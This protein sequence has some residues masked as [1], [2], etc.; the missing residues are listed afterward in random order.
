MTLLL[1]LSALFSGSEVALF[2]LDKEKILTLKNTPKV[3]SEYILSLIEF[4]RRLLITILL[5]NTIVNVGASIISVSLALDIAEDY[6]L[7]KDAVL[8]VQIF[9]LTALVLLIGEITPKIWASKKPLQFAKFSSVPLYWISVLMYPVSKTLA[10]IIRHSIAKIKFDKSKTV[11]STSEFAELADLGIE[12]GTLEEEEHGLIHGIVSFKTVMVREVMTPRVDITSISSDSSF[13][14][15]MQIIVESGHSRIPL[16]GENLDDIIGIVYAK[17]LLPYL[18]DGEHKKT[19]N[20]SKIARKAMFVPETKFINEL[21]KEFQEKKMHVGI[22]VDEYG[23]TAGLISMEDILE[24]IVG[25]IRDE[26]DK[27]ENEI[28]KVGDNVYLVMGKV[29]IYEI[30]E[31]LE[32]QAI[33]ESEDYDTIGGFILNNAGSI[34]Q[35]DYSFVYE[36]YKFTVK[37][38]TNNRV[39]KVLIEIIQPSLTEGAQE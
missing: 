14:E 2:S 10:D 4:P 18:H 16:Y 19:F 28:S 38:V 20:L 5:G 17:D 13:E 33:P 7:E 12:A 34:P 9:V 23:G 6:S 22:V 24:E 39:N 36:N 27:D 3:I 31:L 15:I 29:S 21:M 25:E 37:D 35:K 8:F 1:L 11:I 30:N 26:Y 32:T